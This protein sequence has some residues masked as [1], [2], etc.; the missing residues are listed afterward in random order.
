MASEPIRRFAAPRCAFCFVWCASAQCSRCRST[1]G[2]VGR[3]PSLCEILEIIAPLRKEDS[4]KLK[5]KTTSRKRNMQQ[6]AQLSSHRTSWILKN[7]MN[8]IKICLD[9]YKIKVFRGKAATNYE[10]FNPVFFQQSVTKRE[11]QIAVI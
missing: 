1:L 11:S 9:L 7:S 6:G 2:H 3:L 10:N 4:E 8:Q 5:K